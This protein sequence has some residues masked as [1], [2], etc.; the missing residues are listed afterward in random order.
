MFLNNAESEIVQRPM[1]SQMIVKCP[2]DQ[3]LRKKFVA[4]FQFLFRL[5]YKNNED[6]QEKPTLELGTFG[7]NGKKFRLLSLYYC[8]L[9]TNCMVFVENFLEVLYF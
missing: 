8:L 3:F 1:R 5:S 6:S 2:C 9:I 7:I 4:Y